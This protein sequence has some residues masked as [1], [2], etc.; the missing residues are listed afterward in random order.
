M[1]V[2][3]PNKK[4]QKVL[5]QRTLWNGEWD[6][7]TGRL[8]KKELEYFSSCSLLYVWA[9]GGRAMEGWSE[10]AELDWSRDVD[11]HPSVLLSLP[12]RYAREEPG[13]AADPSS[14]WDSVNLGRVRPLESPF[15]CLHNRT[16]ILCSVYLKGLWCRS[17]RHHVWK[18][19]VKF[20]MFKKISHLACEKEIPEPGFV[21]HSLSV[22]F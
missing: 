8:E 9:L 16:S 17:N 13:M 21:S 18:C 14:S 2:E 7:W 12:T 6:N 3:E 22:S 4:V 15:L 19:F 11:S 1:A 20:T 10:G 5:L